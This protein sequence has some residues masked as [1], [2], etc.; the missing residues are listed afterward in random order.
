MPAAT[1]RAL[2]KAG[3]EIAVGVGLIALL[4]V[5]L[6]LRRIASSFAARVRAV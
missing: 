2:I 6:V 5:M 1:V 3:V 4:L